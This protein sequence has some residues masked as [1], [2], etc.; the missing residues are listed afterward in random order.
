MK[1]EKTS[2]IGFLKS[3]REGSTLIVHAIENRGKK[4]DTDFTTLEK[5]L[6][7][8]QS[9]LTAIKDEIQNKNVNLDGLQNDLGSQL[10]KIDQ[11][12]GRVETTLSQAIATAKS[13]P[14][15]IPKE[16]TIKEPRWWKP[17]NW[18]DL[19]KQLAPLKKALEEIA[20][21]EPQTL[22]IEDGKVAVKVDR[23]GGG[24]GGIKI[25]RIKV[26]GKIAYGT[27]AQG[28]RVLTN[29]NTWYSVPSSVPDEDYLLIINYESVKGT[30]RWGYLNTGTPG[31][32]NGNQ[33]PSHLEIYMPANSTLFFGSDS[34][35]DTINW[36]TKEL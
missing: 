12:L 3:L 18:G 9:K 35:G 36:A 11:S 17:I 25:D 7:E 6:A 2:F 23:I 24:G 22:P 32:A 8:T 5:T 26:Y 16:I 1:F 15:I 33:A 14:V 34:A 13:D 28:Q 29:A 4:H 19:E 10:K 20:K 21:R 30:I 31:T 27:G